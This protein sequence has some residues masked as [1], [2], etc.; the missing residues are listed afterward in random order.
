MALCTAKGL[1]GGNGYTGWC[2]IPTPSPP[3]VAKSAM[4]E[5]LFRLNDTFIFNLSVV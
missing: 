2:D 5:E 3:V 1:R 4:H